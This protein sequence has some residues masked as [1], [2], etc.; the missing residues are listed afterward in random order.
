MKLQCM[1][2]EA[3]RNLLPCWAIHHLVSFPHCFTARRNTNNAHSK[4][5]KAAHEERN[6]IHSV[7]PAREFS[8]LGKGDQLSCVGP[9]L[10]EQCAQG[11]FIIG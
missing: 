6:L 4:P 5:R 3:G 10:V 9:E 2:L 1:E 11:S 7:C 8:L